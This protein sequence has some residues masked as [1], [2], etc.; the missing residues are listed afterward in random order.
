MSIRG[1]SLREE[2]KKGAIEKVFLEREKMSA[3]EQINTKRFTV[4]LRRN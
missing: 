3:Y 1:D 4:P 2:R